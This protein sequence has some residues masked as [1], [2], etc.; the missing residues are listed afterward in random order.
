MFLGN[1]EDPRNFRSVGCGSC[2]AITVWL[3]DAS[4][5]HLCDSKLEPK[6]CSTCG[7]LNIAN[8]PEPYQILYCLDCKILDQSGDSFPGYD[9]D[10]SDFS[11]RNLS[12]SD[13]VDNSFTNCNFSNSYLLNNVLA[14]AFSGCDFSDASLI[15]VIAG[16]G[17]NFD[18]S[19]TFQDCN[20]S[21]ANMSAG[22][23]EGCDFQGSTF[24]L[25]NLTGASFAGANLSNTDLRDAILDGASFEG[26]VLEGTIFPDNALHS[27]SGNSLKPD[28][29][30]SERPTGFREDYMRDPEF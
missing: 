9:F 2:F 24:F 19:S 21:R 20:F 18:L 13:F 16:G 25:T 6:N 7:S 28:G 4:T 3:G 26:A 5:C 23:F 22:K 30:E 8:L 10:D 12:G 29:D 27:A 17:Q 14:S 1:T 15:G 11:N